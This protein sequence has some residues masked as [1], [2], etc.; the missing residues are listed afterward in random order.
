MATVIKPT[1]EQQ[2]SPFAKL[3]EDHAA[4][5]SME[6]GS[7]ISGSVVHITHDFV[8]VDVGFKSEGV[9]PIN[10]FKN[11]QGEM[12][13]E[14]G[15]TIDVF[16]ENLEDDAGMVRLSKERA[17]A[18]RAW[19]SLVKIQDEDGI[20]EGI[21]LSKVKGGLFV[22]VGVKAFLP[23]SQIDTRP[24]RN[25]DKYVGKTFHF[26]IL[27]LNKRRGNI[28]LSRKEAMTK[29][30]SSRKEE[31]LQNIKEGQVMKGTVKNVTDYG[32]FVDL[33][34][35]DGLLH[36]TDMSWGRVNHPSDLFK[37]G[38]DI[39]VVV[40]K[41]DTDTNRVSLGYKQ[42]QADPWSGAEGL[43]TVGSKITGRVVSLTEYGAFVE[44]SPGIEGLVHI[45]EISWNKK[46]KHPSQELEVNQQVD[47]IILDCD[48]P[49]RR[50]ALGLK[51]LKENP[52]NIIERDFPVGSKVSGTVR[53]ITDFGLFVD[54]GVGLDGMIHI[55]D[56]DWVQNFT[57]P[58]DLYKKGD[59]IEALVA[60]IDKENERFSLSLKQLSDNPWDRIRMHYPEGAEVD[61]KVV[62]KGPS[63]AIVEL[64][65]GV[66]GLLPVEEV[67]G[68][69]TGG[70]SV[71]LIVS[72][73]HEESRQF[74]LKQKS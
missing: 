68:E 40:L 54:C 17:D 41:Y 55:S 72:K 16:L 12:T 38:G 48:L 51:Q 8:V 69:L 30:N 45:S 50:V 19:D 4:S 63:G 43:F 33:G 56:I 67:N 3:L 65:E 2:K 59:K 52:W 1:E 74:H 66:R 11:P 20:V 25:L 34:G 24:V 15:D 29:E 46:M 37:V 26:K 73:V 58:Q 13:V 57:V 61:G 44:L 35:I 23:G 22:D 71:A 60:N 18:L 36:V 14:I 70:A 32:A 42:L 6:E 62:F 28:V 7:L 64:E 27:K 39:K 9:I 21:V 5:R 10:E 31:I 49:N 47:A 53:N